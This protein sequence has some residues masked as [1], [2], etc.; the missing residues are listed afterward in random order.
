MEK[1]IFAKPTISCFCFS[2]IYFDNGICLSK[3]FFAKSISEFNKL[4]VDNSKGI[5]QIRYDVSI[6]MQDG[7]NLREKTN[8]DVYLYKPK[9]KLE[10]RI[11]AQ[12]EWI[13]ENLI[14]DKEYDNEDYMDFVSLLDNIEHNTISIDILSDAARYYRRLNYGIQNKSN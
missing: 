12:S 13:N 14:I 8:I 5:T 4:I 3:V 6:F 7:K 9:Q 1:I 2:V 11:A 10:D